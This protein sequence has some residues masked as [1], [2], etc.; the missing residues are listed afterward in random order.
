MTHLSRHL[1]LAVKTYQLNINEKSSWWPKLS[2]WHSLMKPV[3]QQSYFTNKFVCLTIHYKR[4]KFLWKDSNK[5]LFPFQ[6]VLFRLRNTIKEYIIWY[7]WEQIILKSVLKAI[8]ISSTQQIQCL[9]TSSAFRVL[10]V[11][12]R[13]QI[14]SSDEVRQFIYANCYLVFNHATGALATQK[15]GVSWITEETKVSWSI[16]SK[17][18][19]CN[20]FR[21]LWKLYF[22]KNKLPTAT[23]GFKTVKQSEHVNLCALRDTIY[24]RLMWT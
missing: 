22:T 3:E 20:G 1:C 14:A 10:P 21:E 17:L 11:P 15:P 9:A 5:T 8:C 23:K 4:M 16:R 19:L 6:N 7:W 18:N 2:T 12:C 24:R 13:I